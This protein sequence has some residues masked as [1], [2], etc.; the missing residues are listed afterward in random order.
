MK[1][2]LDSHAL[3]WSAAN[4]DRLSDTAKEIIKDWDNLLFVSIVTFWEI[5]I[6]SSLGKL[7]LKFPVERVLNYF[8]DTNIQILRI[9][10]KH[11][12]A[13]RDLPKHHQDPFDRMLIAQAMEHDLIVISKDYH[14]RSYKGIRLIW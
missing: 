4:D 6:K 12:L 2:I 8:H 7:D 1:Y 11:A 14:F 9:E 3:L 13:V 10:I 5:C